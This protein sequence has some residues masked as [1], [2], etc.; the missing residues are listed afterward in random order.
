[1]K[2]N[3]LTASLLT[4][5]IA[6]G[7][8]GSVSAA[9]PAQDAAT[10]AAVR[11]AVAANGGNTTVDVSADGTVVTLNGTAASVRDSV[12]ASSA[13]FAVSGVV[14]VANNLSYPEGV[15]PV[16][17]ATRSASGPT[18]QDMDGD[19]VDEVG[20]GPDADVD[21]FQDLDNDGVDEVGPGPDAEL[22]NVQDLDGD[23]VDEVGP[24]PDA[25][26]DNVQDLDG[27]GVDEVGPG[28]DAP[29]NDETDLDRDGD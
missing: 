10:A 11:N 7:L 4:A 12:A 8:A 6:T 15:A 1:M 25:N 14:G 19:G 26:L 9:D 16:G 18:L 29:V 20:P 21:N 24:G 28:P 23:G 13:A 22:N 27:D 17:V 2:R 3:I 5:A